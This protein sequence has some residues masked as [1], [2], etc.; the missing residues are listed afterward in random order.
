M[1]SRSPSPPASQCPPYLWV[2][3]KKSPL[4]H[5]T[6]TSWQ[7]GQPAEGLCWEAAE[8]T[9]WQDAYGPARGTD[10]T[11][12]PLKHLISHLPS[13]LSPSVSPYPAH[14]APLPNTMALD[15]N[16]CLQ[17]PWEQLHYLPPGMP[18]HAG[19]LQRQ[20]LSLFLRAWPLHA[21]VSPVPVLDS[22]SSSPTQA[23]SSPT[24]PACLG[25]PSPPSSSADFSQVRCHMVPVKPHIFSCRLKRHTFLCARQFT[26]CSIGSISYWISQKN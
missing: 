8:G 13:L 26:D 3:A 4:I 20:E 1:W 19:S 16:T 14:R 22:L 25:S 6:H 12:N 24:A 2:E 21:P 23:A 18:W 10:T 11:E 9:G 7:G 15:T 17:G 5:A